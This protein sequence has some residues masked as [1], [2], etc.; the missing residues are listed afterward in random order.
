MPTIKCK[1][2]ECR[3]NKNIM[4]DAP[5]VQVEHNGVPSSENSAQTQCETFKPQS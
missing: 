3:Y 2:I 1:V 5:M 4:C